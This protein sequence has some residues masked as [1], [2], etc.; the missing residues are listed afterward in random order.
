[1]PL[2][3]Q[4]EVKIPADD[5]PMLLAI[6]S[7]Y[8]GQL[9]KIENSIPGAEKGGTRSHATQHMRSEAQRIERILADQMPNDR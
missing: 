1:M 9:K 7:F 3:E 5:L 6:V 4:S 8:I 2:N